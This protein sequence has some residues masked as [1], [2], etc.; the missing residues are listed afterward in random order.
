[1][2]V[3]AAKRRREIERRMYAVLSEIIRY[4]IFM[5]LVTLLAYSQRDNNLYQ[6]NKFTEDSFQFK[7]P[8]GEALQNV[9]FV[10]DIWT[11]LKEVGTGFSLTLG[12]LVTTS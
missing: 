6:L 5:Y 7:M 3:T 11:W 4:L 10:A 9:T 2:C 8:S 12:S 1:M